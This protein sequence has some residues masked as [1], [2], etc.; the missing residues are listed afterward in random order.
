MVALDNLGKGMAGQA[1]Q[2]MNIALGIPEATPCG[3]PRG[4]QLTRCRELPD[5]SISILSKLFDSKISDANH[6]LRNCCY[7]VGNTP[8]QVLGPH[9][10]CCC[11]G[12]E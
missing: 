10:L 9:S 5:S 8:H 2:A 11:P 7:K 1:V 6:G 4:F 12:D 3:N